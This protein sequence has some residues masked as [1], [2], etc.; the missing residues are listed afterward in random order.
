[1]KVYGCHDILFNWYLPGITGKSSVLVLR[2]EYCSEG[3]NGGGD[4]NFV[5]TIWKILIA[6]GIMPAGNG[7][8]WNL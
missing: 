3:G 6:P 4:G 1:M 2:A 8:N 5:I 7:E